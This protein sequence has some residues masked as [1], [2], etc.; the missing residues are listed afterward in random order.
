[1]AGNRQYDHEYKVQ[2]VKLAKEI[3]QAKPL[4]VKRHWKMLL[5]RIRVSV[6]P[7]SIQTG[8]ASIPASFTGK[9]YRNMAY[10]K[11]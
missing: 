10:N 3:G 1:M 8:E 4:Y 6:E 5:K 9:R 11:V 7:L 2:A